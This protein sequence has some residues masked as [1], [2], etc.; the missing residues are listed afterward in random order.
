M[1]GCRTETVSLSG[2]TPIELLP[3]QRVPLA[4]SSTDSQL[5][6]GHRVVNLNDEGPVLFG[7]RGTVASLYNGKAEVIFDSPF[8][9][10]HNLDGK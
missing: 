4:Q 3:P 7:Q 2:V 6:L 9:S 8:L 1:Q 5:K 10:A